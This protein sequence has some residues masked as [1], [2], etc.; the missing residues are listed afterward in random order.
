LC[1]GAVQI[2]G[3][4]G[5]GTKEEAPGIVCLVLRFKPP[6]LDHR[7]E[8]ELVVSRGRGHGH[9]LGQLLRLLT[10]RGAHTHTVHTSTNR[11]NKIKNK[12][13]RTRI[14]RETRARPR[15]PYLQHRSTGSTNRMADSRGRG[16]SLAKIEF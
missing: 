5:G 9:R 1:T 10:A 14:K 2:D 16:A 11:S 8:T 15:K 3:T 12:K 7:I 6:L 13:T 4:S